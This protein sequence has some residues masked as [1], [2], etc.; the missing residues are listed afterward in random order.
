MSRVSI[1]YAK[2][3]FSLALE[4]NKLDDVSKDLTMIGDVLKADN[5]FK[6]FVHNPLISGMKKATIVKEIFTGKISDRT[7]DFLQL[8]SQKKRLNQL[9]EVLQRY[10]QL[11]M[12]HNNQVKAQVVGSEAISKKQLD[13]IKRHVESMTQKTVLISTKQD[14]ALIGGFKVE[15]EDII[16]DNSIRNQLHKLKSKL[17]S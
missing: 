13:D 17:V 14:P 8:L 5:A 10:G 4:E 1:R 11:L 15:I 9:P 6:D 3:L 7:L 16:I 2:A 12:Q